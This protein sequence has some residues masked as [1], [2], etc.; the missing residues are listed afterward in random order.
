MTADEGREQQAADGDGRPAPGPDLLLAA[1]ADPRRRQLF[2]RLRRAGPMSAGALAEGEPVTR[3]AV[4]Q[5]LRV[6][7][8]AGLVEVQR[9]GRERHYA[10]P[11]AALAPLAQWLGGATADRGVDPL[12]GE[13]RKWQ[14]EAPH[15]DHDVLA[16]MMYFVQVGRYIQQSSE[17]AAATVGLRF[18]DVTLLGALRRLGPPYEST[19]TRLSQT[20]WVTLPGMIK[21]LARLE[22]MG[23]LHRLPDPDDGR[24]VLLRLT[25]TGLATLREM[26]A[27]RQP[28][29]Y[30]ALLDL[31]A[32]SRAALSATLRQLLDHIDRR[33]GQR[34]PPYVIRPS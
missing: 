24:G 9:Q 16:L 28:P 22:A 15:I 25:E 21:R 29:E 34:R 10:V 11:E 23:L 8:D 4:S 17:E 3:S 20:F 31:P 26:L 14:A 19:P 7:L 32:A 33:H 18:S 6:L 27:N 2:D 13:L 30:Y 12:A 5:H 1:L